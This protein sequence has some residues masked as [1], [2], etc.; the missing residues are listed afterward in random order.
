MRTDSYHGPMHRIALL[1][2]GGTIE[3][4]YVEQDGSMENT[5]SR[6]FAA[7]CRCPATAGLRDHRARS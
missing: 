6:R 1:T 3:K 4:R 2:T 7:A 5:R